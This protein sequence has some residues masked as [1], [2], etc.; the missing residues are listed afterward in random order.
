[1]FKKH[2]QKHSAVYKITTHDPLFKIACLDANA[3]PHLSVYKIRDPTP[4]PHIYYINQHIPGHP[5]IPDPPDS[6][7]GNVSYIY[8]GVPQ[9]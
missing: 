2:Q 5:A 6:I 1:M 4:K 8:R 3:C 7:E 9:R